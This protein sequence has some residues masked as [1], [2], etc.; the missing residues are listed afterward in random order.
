M[1]GGIDFL[2]RDPANTS[3]AP[4]ASPT[5]PMSTF[6]VPPPP[7]WEASVPHAMG[8]AAPATTDLPPMGRDEPVVP[9]RDMTRVGG[10]PSMFNPIPFQ[11]SFDTSSITKMYVRLPFPSGC[12]DSKEEDGPSF[13]LDFSGLRDP[14]SMLQFLYACDEM[15]SKSLEGYSTAG[16][17]YDPTRECL[18]ID[19]E[20]PDEGD[21]LD[22]PQEG[23]Q[24]PPRVQEAVVLGG[25]EREMSSTFPIID[26][27][28]SRP[29]QTL[30]TN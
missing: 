24:P 17:G 4:G 22:M 28:V 2:S 10:E 21:H 3:I 27:G 9:W 14:E 15:L 29:S 11:S 18:H 7:A 23:D 25:T 30:W 26:F 16:E 5:A 20:I 12:L 8:R 13:G 6:L 19:L 1:V